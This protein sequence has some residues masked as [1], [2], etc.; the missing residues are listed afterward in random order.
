MSFN[1]NGFGD[2]HFSQVLRIN[3]MHKNHVNV[4]RKIKLLNFPDR[5]NA[6]RSHLYNFVILKILPFITIRLMLV[7]WLQLQKLVYYK[8]A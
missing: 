5:Y 7:N 3:F 2:P 6:P 8:E 1:N 4:S